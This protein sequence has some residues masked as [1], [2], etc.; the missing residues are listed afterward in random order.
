MS[1]EKKG[2][3]PITDL[4][5]HL[6]DQATSVDTGEMVEII[7]KN[8]LGIEWRSSLRG[9]WFMQIPS[10]ENLVK[11]WNEVGSVYWFWD[12]TFADGTESRAFVVVPPGLMREI[13]DWLTSVEKE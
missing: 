4:G 8:Q 11:N 9:D 13:K 1:E 12:A 10:A 5:Q 6:L 2:C 3:Q 7:A